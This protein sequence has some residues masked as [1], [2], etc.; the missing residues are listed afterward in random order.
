MLW[1][2]DAALAAFSAV[3]F[4]ISKINFVR[5]LLATADQEFAPVNSEYKSGL[6]PKDDYVCKIPLSSRFGYSFTF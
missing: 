6:S 4:S 2:K 5:N 3:F 1:T